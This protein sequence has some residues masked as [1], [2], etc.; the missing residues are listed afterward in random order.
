MRK[1]I[2]HIASGSYATGIK[3]ATSFKTPLLKSQ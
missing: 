2:C 1:N 3:S